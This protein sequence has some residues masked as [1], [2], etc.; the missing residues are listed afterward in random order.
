MICYNKHG[1]SPALRRGVPCSE[2]EVQP[3]YQTTFGRVPGL[4]SVIG[5]RMTAPPTGDDSTLLLRG[6]CVIDPKNGIHEVRDILIR[7]GE[8]AETGCDIRAE[9]GWMLI[10]VSGLQVWPGLI[11]M[12]LHLGDLFEVSTEPIACAAR[13]GVTIGLSPG[14]GNTFMAPALLG[15]EVDRGVP[16]SLGVYLG[17]ANVLSTCL[18]QDEL[19]R[20]FRGELDP[21]TM[22]RKM[23]RNAITN[24]TA[25][26]AMGIKDHMG[27][28]IMP[29]ESVDRLFDLTSRA[30]LIYMSH[31]QDP[32][33]AERMVGLSQGRPLHLGHATAA[34]CGTHDSAESGMARVLDL[35]GGNVTAEF[36]TTMLRPG[37]G[38]RE[39]LQ[40]SPAA[41]KMA[42]DALRDGKVRILVSDGQNEAT[43]KGFGDTRDN[44]PALLE[45]AQMGV[46]TLDEAVAA[47]TCHPAALIAERTGCRFFAE[48]TGHLGPGAL[49]SITVVEPDRKRAVYTIVN[50]EIVSFESRLVRR[51]SGAGGWV[52][53]FGML[54]RTGVGDLAMT[55]YQD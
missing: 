46:L 32:A 33:H 14:A 6:G 13:D 21:E 49:A 25:A 30:G 19:V 43:M 50:G 29:D 55:A 24:T 18:T 9:K 31:T 15:A 16:I 27:H 53:R 11:D 12:H 17:G 22:A 20:L 51:G 47:M 8:I 1:A 4:A 5:G 38:C 7:G 35:V 52:S 3:L 41:Q 39:G 26:L 28:F 10:N 48:K 42:Y 23:T 36:V 34:G 44:I 54:R 40:M 37:R 45:L 2:R